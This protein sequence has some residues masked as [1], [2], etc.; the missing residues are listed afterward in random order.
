MI[1]QN[2]HNVNARAFAK[3]NELFPS[4]NS[5]SSHV[6]FGSMN[7]M[8]RASLDVYALVGSSGMEFCCCSL[9]ESGLGTPSASRT[10]SL[11]RG[12]GLE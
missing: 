10:G 7:L 9:D 11:H 2:G 8:S 4:E 5:L 1:L 3:K 12:T 6:I